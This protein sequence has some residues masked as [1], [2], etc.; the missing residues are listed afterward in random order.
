MAYQR[1]EASESLARHVGQGSVHRLVLTLTLLLA[2]TT[3]SVSTGLVVY[4]AWLH[5]LKNGFFALGFAVLSAKMA[6]SWVLWRDTDQQV[7]SSISKI[8]EG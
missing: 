3:V 8:A 5:D 7:S 6:L 2:L 1:E 4:T